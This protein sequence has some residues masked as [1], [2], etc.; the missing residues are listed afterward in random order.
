M[1]LIHGHSVQEAVSKITAK[2]WQQIAAACL[3]GCLALAPL[4][5]IEAIADAMGRDNF[6]RLILGRRP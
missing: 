2:T 6:R 5:G 4:F 3:L 1:S